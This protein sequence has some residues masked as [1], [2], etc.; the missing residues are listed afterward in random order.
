MSSP[1][2]VFINCPYD[3]DY[4]GLFD[5]IVFA[6]LYCGFEPRSAVEAQGTAKQR[7]PR[8]LKLIRD[9]PLGIHDLSRTELSGL[10]Q[11]KLPRFNMPLELGLFIGAREFGE[12][13]KGKDYLVFERRKG[14]SAIC[15]SD[16]GGADPL[17][18][19]NQS[20]KAIEHVRNWLSMHGKG[21]IPVPGPDAIRNDYE[22]FQSDLPAILAE[23]RLRAREMTFIDFR[24]AASV[25]LKARSDD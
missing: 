24:K 20:H 23:W 13:Q 2:K 22:S 15:C 25:W 21:A 3:P 18:H 6:V 19:G 5:A 17:A 16:L 14:D 10:R 9:C 7:F 12:D 11:R 1:V 8:I 4:R